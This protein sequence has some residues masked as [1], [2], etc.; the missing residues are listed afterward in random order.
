MDS[1]VPDRHNL[2]A[3][4]TSGLIITFGGIFAHVNRVYG[5]RSSRFESFIMNGEPC[6]PTWDFVH[7]GIRLL[8]YQADL[9]PSSKSACGSLATVLAKSHGIGETFARADC[10]GSQG[11][12]QKQ[13]HL[14]SFVLADKFEFA[15]I[16]SVRDAVR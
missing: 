2:S 16:E 14:E 6:S 13:L 12:C 11:A 5:A 1:A 7:S 10:V 9:P 4:I 8:V 15:F 3:F